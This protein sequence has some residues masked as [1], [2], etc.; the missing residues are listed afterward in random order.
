VAAL[1]RPGFPD[2]AGRL[3]ERA[4][5]ECTQ[6][7]ATIARGARW[8]ELLGV[9]Q[10]EAVDDTVVLAKLCLVGDGDITV[11]YRLLYK[12]AGPVSSC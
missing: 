10:V 7:V 5:V 6:A 12:G 4:E 1:T 8:S 9:D 3:T 11:W 2:A